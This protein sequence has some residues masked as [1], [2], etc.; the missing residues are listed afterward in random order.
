RV[1][2]RSATSKPSATTPRAS[3]PWPAQVQQWDIFEIALSGAPRG[4]PFDVHLLARF[5]SGKSS[6]EARGFYDG[7][8]VYRV[9]FMPPQQGVWRYQTR[10][11]LPELSGRTG[12][13]TCVQASA[14]NHG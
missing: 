13:F 4:N 10:S 12:E 1:L 14:N 8:G 6:V 5:T 9:R 2:F 11:D 3:A 7:D